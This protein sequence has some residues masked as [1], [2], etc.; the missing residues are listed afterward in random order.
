MLKLDLN[1]DKEVP[2][3]TRG[4]LKKVNKKLS[5]ILG[6]EE[7]KCLHADYVEYSGKDLLVFFRE[8][9]KRH[10]FISRWDKFCKEGGLS[11]IDKKTK[12]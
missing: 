1:A 7:K 12:K 9:N 4:F 6:L 3:A 10:R 2:M 5:S 11:K 8:P